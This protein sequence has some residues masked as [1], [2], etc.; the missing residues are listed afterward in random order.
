MEFALAAGLILVFAFGALPPVANAAT[1]FSAANSINQTA[2]SSM[3]SVLNAALNGFSNA[4]KMLGT[5]PGTPYMP[6]A[7]S[8]AIFASLTANGQT[9][10]SV[11]PNTAVNYA[12]TSS[13][14]TQFNTSL[15][16]LN[17]AGI[18]VASDPCGNQASASWP[19]A[20][21]ASGATPG[22]TAACQVGYSYVITYTATGSEGS[23]SSKIMI[24]VSPASA[25]TVSFTANGG[26]SISV[27]PGAEVNYVWNSSN[28]V[29]YDSS[30]DSITDS[31]GDSVQEDGCGNNLT[32]AGVNSGAFPGPSGE[33]PGYVEPCQAGYSYVLTYAASDVNGHRAAASVHVTA[34]VA[35]LPSFPVSLRVGAASANVRSD[36]NTSAPLAGSQTLSPGDVFTATSEVQGQSIDGNDLWFVSSLGNYIWSGTVGLADPAAYAAANSG[37]ET[38]ATAGGGSNAGG[39]GIVQGKP[40]TISA[41]QLQADIANDYGKSNGWLTNIANLASQAGYLVYES[42]DGSS[43]VIRDPVTNAVVAAIGETSG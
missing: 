7:P 35:P 29:S 25:A 36:S 5:S 42:Q 19:L 17:S 22:V 20:T 38:G 34:T 37:L 10:L 40:A 16:I 26:K 31:S 21:T 12:W 2:I 32:P 41:A 13:N 14:A 11:P 30:L 24:T 8:R 3:N 27:P 9:L 6:I 28:G 39:S 33:T 23:A 43:L 4:L 18:S 1:T 15:Q